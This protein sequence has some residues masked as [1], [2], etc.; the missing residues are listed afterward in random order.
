MKRLY[1]TA[2]PDLLELFENVTG[3][4][5]STHSVFNFAKRLMMLF[6]SYIHTILYELLVFLCCI[7]LTSL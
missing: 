6:N 4:R 2:G 3:V 5:V 7:H 1:K